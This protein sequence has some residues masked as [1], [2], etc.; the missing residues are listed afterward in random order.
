MTWIIINLILA[1]VAIV[2]LLLLV[3]KP[4]TMGIEII[5]EQEPQN[6]DLMEPM[7]PQ[8]D[9][10]QVLIREHGQPYGTETGVRSISSEQAPQQDKGISF[11]K[12]LLLPGVI[13]LS[14]TYLGLK[15]ANYSMML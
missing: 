11:M 12:A 4:V 1:F 8:D 13:P 2:D 7:I 6:P 15:L 3:P 10:D 9:E 5:E 14:L